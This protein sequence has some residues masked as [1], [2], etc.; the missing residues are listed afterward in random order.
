MVRRFERELYRGIVV[1]WLPQMCGSAGSHGNV[2]S[3]T[4]GTPEW[5]HTRNVVA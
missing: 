2:Q 5:A 3:F 1:H 4:F